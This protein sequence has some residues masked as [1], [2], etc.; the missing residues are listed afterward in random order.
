MSFSFLFTFM[1][2]FVLVK[3]YRKKIIK[4]SKITP[5]NFIHYTTFYD[6]LF[7]LFFFFVVIF[8]NDHNTLQ[9]SQFFSIITILFYYQ[10]IFPL[11]QYFSI[12]TILFHYHNTLQS[13]LYSSMI[14]IFFNHHYL[15]ENKLKYEFRHLTQVFYY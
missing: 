3:F 13:S 2:L 7:N 4:K 10:N 11:S 12:I 9:S 14:T 5:D 15:Y 6:H 1:R 8:F